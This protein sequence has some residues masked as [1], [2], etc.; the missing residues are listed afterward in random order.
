M[1]IPFS[2]VKKIAIDTN[3]FIYV[4]E[5]NPAFGEQ[6]K[7]LLE[8]VEEGLYTAVTSAISLAEILVKPVRDGNLTLEK[9][10]K[11][12]FAHFPNLFVAPVDT[13]VAERAAFLRGKYGIK[14]PDA[15]LIAT[16]IVENAEVFVTNDLRLE[17]VE[18]IPCLRLDQ[19]Q[20]KEERA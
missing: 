5:E 17:Q 13:K 2:S 3:I 18:E 12:L 16:A 4:F 15:L 14:M 10:Y 7:Q 20:H 11:L 6:A 1:V 9:Q 19:L 8:Q